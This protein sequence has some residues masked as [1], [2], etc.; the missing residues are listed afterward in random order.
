M[1]D[2]S[3][4]RPQLYFSHTPTL[5]HVKPGAV[6]SFDNVVISKIAPLSAYSFTSWAP[7]RNAGVGYPLWPSIV[8]NE[9]GTVRKGRL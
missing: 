4:P 7:W 9:N 8:M 2:G 5:F 3:L 1:F 6:L